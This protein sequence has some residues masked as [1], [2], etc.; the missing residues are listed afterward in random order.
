MSLHTRSKFPDTIGKTVP[1][2]HKHSVLK[3]K[4]KQVPKD[5]SSKKEFDAAGQVGVSERSTLE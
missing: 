1:G 5:S 3:P 4:S 2:N